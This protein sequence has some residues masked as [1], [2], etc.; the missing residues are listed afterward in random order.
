MS[1][2]PSSVTSLKHPKKLNLRDIVDQ[3]ETLELLSKL[4]EE[5]RT[6]V[7]NLMDHVIHQEKRSV[8]DGEA[9]A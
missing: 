4:D 5:D 9:L 8:I 6:V 2:P 1:A 3:E 7:S